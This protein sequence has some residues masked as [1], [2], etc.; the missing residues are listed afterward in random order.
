MITSVSLYFSTFQNNFYYTQ[1]AFVFYL[2]ESFYIVHNDFKNF[3]FS[4]LQKD[5]YIVHEH[6]DA[7]CF[8]FL[9]KILIL[10]T[11]LFWKSFF[12]F[13][14]FDNIQPT[15]LYIAN[16]FIKRLTKKCVRLFVGLVF[17]RF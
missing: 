11:S 15:F 9:T 13:A 10:F 6:I 2:Q 4:L 1:L 14:F 7:F 5:F 17:M 12:A 8:F 16:T 3:C